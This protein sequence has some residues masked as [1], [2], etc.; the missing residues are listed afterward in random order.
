MKGKISGS[1]GNEYKNIYILGCCT[2]SSGRNLPTFQRC[3]LPPTSGRLMDDG[4][5]S[6]SETP[7][8]FHQTTRRNIPEDSHLQ[9][10]ERLRNE[11]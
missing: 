7:V 3:L 5:V 6:T 8:S 4:A 2:V 10:D 1:H 9:E 11:Q